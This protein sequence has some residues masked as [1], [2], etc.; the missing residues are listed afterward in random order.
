MRAIII[1]DIKNARSALR[2]DIQDYCSNIEIVGEADGVTSAFEIIKSLIPDLI[3]LDIQMNDGTGFELLK[4]LDKND[5]KQPHVIFTTAFD[6]YAV[7]AFQFS[8][9]DYLLKPID[10][11][12]LIKSVSKVNQLK[13]IS[14][15]EIENLENKAYS[16]KKIVVHRQDKELIFNVKDIVYCQ[17]DGAYTQIVTENGKKEL[18]SKNLKSFELML[19]SYGFLRIHH[20]YLVN[21]QKIVEFDKNSMLLKMKGNYSLPVSHRKREALNS[22]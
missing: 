21:K 1:D 19:E 17:S 9:I 20:S 13:R 12:L 18:A 15:L 6:Q 5:I 8:A 11:Q 7:Q 10:Y 14:S 22:I 16:D 4:L 3:F 2:G